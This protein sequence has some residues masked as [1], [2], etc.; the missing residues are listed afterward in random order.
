M[1][2][3]SVKNIK[4]LPKM[5]GGFVIVALIV[6]VVGLVNLKGEIALKDAMED[7][8][9][10]HLVSAENLMFAAEARALID[11]AE[12]KLMDKA[13]DAQGVADTFKDSEALKKVV[14][15]SLKTY[16]GLPKEEVD[17]WNTLKPTLVVWWK[18]HEDYLQIARAYWSRPTDAAYEAMEEQMKVN[19]ARFDESRKILH[20]LVMQNSRAAEIAMREGKATT[21]Q[22]QRVAVAGM[23]AGFVLSL[24]LGIALALS[25]SRPL[26]KGVAFAELVAGGDLTRTFDL[27]RK[28]E[29]GKLAGALN[30]MVEKLRGMAAT[31]RE[32]SVQV[33]SSSGEVA[34]SA[35]KLAEGAQSQASSL[36]ESSAAMEELTASVDHVAEN[37]QAQAA[38]AEQGSSSMTQVDRAIV[39]VSRSLDQ[40][41]ELAE[42]S[43]TKA[44]EGAK[45]VRQVV[46]EMGVIADSSEKIGGIVTVISDIA[47]QTNLLALN[48][49]IE[50]AR[51]GEHGRGFAVVADEVSKLA[52]R[53]STSAKEIERL[54]RESVKNVGRGVETAHGSRGA[55]EQISSASQKVKEMIAS[56]SS[57]MT[58]QVEAVRDLTKVLANVNEMSQGISSATQEQTTNARQV[59]KAIESVNEITQTAA[60]S[61]Q[62]MS[63]ATTQLSG[64]ALT[65]QKTIGQ[66][67]IDGTDALAAVAA[68]DAAHGRLG[69]PEA[70]AH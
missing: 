17:I 34:A 51:A 14:E 24:V 4:L 15:Q 53:S 46:D 22:V 66:F 52:D 41:A 40:I 11:S 45:A 36:E 58:Q 20:D 8:G 70:L 61:A 69:A 3:G 35:Q 1:L 21:A 56:L 32:S 39:E 26:R 30:G 13:L 57:S 28:D 33:A 42:Q 60:S 49:S 6:I 44:A 12:N 63:A 31:I 50:A 48:A 68:A 55:M 25:I 65:L 2:E 18:A 47:D 16:E 59:A 62:E 9:A 5:L 7:I 54:I 67:K 38:A 19:D 27:A 43:V 37:A 10:N 29:I 64:M 23:A